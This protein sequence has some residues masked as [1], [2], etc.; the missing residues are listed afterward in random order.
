MNNYCYVKKGCL[1]WSA[2]LILSAH[3]GIKKLILHYI[4]IEEKIFLK[5]IDFWK[6]IS[7]IQ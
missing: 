7:S 1:K 3:K 5:K 2:L 6:Y 4:G